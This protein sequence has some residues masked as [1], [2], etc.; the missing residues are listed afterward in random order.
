MSFVPFMLFMF[1]AF[2]KP[3]IRRN[4]DPSSAKA[5][6]RSGRI[7]SGAALREGA[8][9]LVDLP[10]LDATVHRAAARCAVVRDRLIRAEAAGHQTLRRHALHDQVGT[11]GFRTAE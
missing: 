11:D 5:Q 7:H 9:V 4:S 3:F 1:P 10:K 8:M 6:R 2:Q